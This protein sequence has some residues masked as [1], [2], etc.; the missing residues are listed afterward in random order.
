MTKLIKVTLLMII[1]AVNALN[2]NDGL[3]MFNDSRDLVVQDGR[4]YTKKAINSSDD[5]KSIVRNN[6]T[7]D[8]CNHL[9]TKRGGITNEYYSRWMEG[10]DFSVTQFKLYGRCR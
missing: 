9:V 4:D 7:I 3:Y 10:C 6:Q 8:V 2:A 5:F 1:V